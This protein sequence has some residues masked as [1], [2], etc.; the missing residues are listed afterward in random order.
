MH[1]AEDEG[2]PRA[3]V[4]LDE[5]RAQ[6]HLGE[7]DGDGSSGNKKKKLWYLDSGA[8]NHMIGEREAFSE[9]DTGVVGIVKFGDGSRAEI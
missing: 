6:V 9:L 1:D 8:N 2:V 3:P 7:E 4:V 5:R